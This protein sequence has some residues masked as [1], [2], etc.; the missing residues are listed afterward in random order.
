MSQSRRFSNPFLY[1]RIASDPSPT[2]TP[3]PFHQLCLV[4]TGLMSVRTN[5]GTQKEWAATT[6]FSIGRI[7]LRLD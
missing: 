5:P 7:A 2:N 3:K 6:E 1:G 4:I